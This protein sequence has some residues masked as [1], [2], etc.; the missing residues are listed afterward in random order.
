MSLIFFLS[1]SFGNSNIKFLA[2]L[3]NILQEYPILIAVSSLSPVN[4]Q[5][6]MFASFIF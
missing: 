4:T 3:D 1:S 6:F 5:N 2:Y